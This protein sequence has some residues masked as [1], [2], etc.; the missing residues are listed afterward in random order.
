M[1]RSRTTRCVRRVV[2]DAGLFDIFDV[3][4]VEG[5]FYRIDGPD[6]LPVAIVNERFVERF[7]KEAIRSGPHPGRP[8]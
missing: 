5:V 7:R 3:R 2:H 6:A 8:S 4:P 1:R